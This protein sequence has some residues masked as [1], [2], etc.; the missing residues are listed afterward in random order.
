MKTI[1]TKIEKFEIVRF[2]DSFQRNGI[3]E[4]WNIGK[5]DLIQYTVLVLGIG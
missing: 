4:P 3:M 5:L 2:S 1:D